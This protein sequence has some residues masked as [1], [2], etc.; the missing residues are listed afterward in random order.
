MEVMSEVFEK[1]VTTQD[2]V[3]AALE[4]RD[5]AAKAEARFFALLSWGEQRPALWKDAGRTFDEFLEMHH[6]CKAARFRAYQQ[7]LER[8]LGQKVIEQIG[9]QPAIAV[10]RI[11]SPAN[12]EKA[13]REL[14]AWSTEHGTAPSAEYARHIV[15][16]AD[17]RERVMPATKR[18][19]LLAEKDRL[20]G[21]LKEEVRTLKQKVK[22]LEQEVV[23]LKAAPKRNKS[24]A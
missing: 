10:S 3:A 11:E 22:A 21:K 17:P 8:G 9:L 15:L 2:F 7:A 23:T 12:R 24:A 18:F 1:I 20:I 5:L 14:I 6:I 19:E 16:K 4:M 13:A